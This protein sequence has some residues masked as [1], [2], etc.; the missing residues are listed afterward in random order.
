[1]SIISR[2]VSWFGERCWLYGWLV[3]IAFFFFFIYPIHSPSVDFNALRTSYVMH[4]ASNILM[5][6]ESIDQ[7]TFDVICA[8]CILIDSGHGFELLLTVL[9]LRNDNIDT[10]ELNAL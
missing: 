7:N 3:V 9:L 4:V 8:I 10:W 1:M 5:K 6:F 2:G